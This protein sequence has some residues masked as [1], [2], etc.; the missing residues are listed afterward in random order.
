MGRAGNNKNEEFGHLSM[1]LTNPKKNRSSVALRAR[2]MQASQAVHIVIRPKTAAEPL[3]AIDQCI[4][5]E[6]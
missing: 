3:I 2:R 6:S 1:H 5:V 4:S